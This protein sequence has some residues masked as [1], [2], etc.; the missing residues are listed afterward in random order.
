MRF[1]TL[2]RT[3]R[4]GLVLAA[5]LVASWNL[6]PAHATNIERVVSPR[7]IELWLVRE[8]SVP[9]I[10]MDFAFQGGASQDPAGK[11]GVASMMVDLLDEGAGDFDS[12]AYHERVEAKAIELGFSAT[13]DY[14]N[15]SLRTLVE[16]EEEAATLLKL[17]LTA[18][19]F[20]AD[21]VERIR[22]QELSI[23][24][25]Q[26]TSPNDLASNRWWA[27]AFAGHPYAHPPRGTLESVPTI[28]AG[29]LRA[30]ARRVLA[31]ETLKVGIVGNIDAAAAGALV[32]KVFGD[33][34][35][36]AELT[37]VPTIA[38]HGLGERVSIDLDV[39]QTVL[40]IGGAG[41][42]RDDPDFMAAYVVNHIL[43]GGSFSSRLYRE[44]REE[45][46]LAYSVFST[47]VPLQ[48]AAL[49]M[50]ATATRADR[51][52][53][54]LD[55]VENEIRRLAETGPTQ[56]ELDK[57]KS[58]L[59]GSFALRFDTSTKIASQL[60]Q[61]QIDKLGIDYIKK[62]NGL[63]DAVGMDDVKRVSKR[64]LD[65]RM[66]VATVGRP[67]ALLAKDTTKETVPGATPVKPT[68]AAALRGSAPAPL[69]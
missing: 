42:R 60:V 12:K 63:I 4:R 61:M 48:H 19:R 13:R 59:K 31:R 37:P 16:N 49:F 20:D 45:R 68:P 9:L 8:P 15:G 55:V 33:L 30:Y 53:E 5:M 38:P 6:T 36:K 43:G 50:T 1:S 67:A 57:A 56:E 64:L 51:A 2:R 66:L 29:D 34:P 14:I 26:S 23:L 27:T 52:G 21:A 40:M 28:T 39:P 22:G 44:V 17:A 54:T 46:G 47:L 18:P 11:P 58:F 65:G 24:R 3:T 41:L 32:D 7:G 10:A 25:R 62:R 69:D 35:A